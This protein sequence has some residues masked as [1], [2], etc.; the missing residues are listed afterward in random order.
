MAPLLLILCAIGGAVAMPRLA[1]QVVVLLAPAL[2][3]LT[4]DGRP[5]RPLG[6]AAPAPPEA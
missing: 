3:L 6:R 4:F 1:S 5:G 2:G